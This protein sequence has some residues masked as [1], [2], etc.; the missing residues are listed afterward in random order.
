[1]IMRI[2]K[3]IINGVLYGCA[4]FTFTLVAIDT[5]LDSSLSILPHQ[6]TRLAVGAICIGIGCCL[7]T[8]IYEEDRLKIHFR[9]IV[10]I[11]ICVMSLLISFAI[12]GG[13]PDGDGLGIALSFTV[14]ELCFGLIFCIVSII[15]YY[16]EARIIRNKLNEKLDCYV[17]RNPNQ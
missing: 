17:L 4:M 5:I 1:M 7:S 12:S 9:F 14:A 6:Y 13:M 3:I 16:Q 11:A 8:L 15:Y 10:Q 2:M